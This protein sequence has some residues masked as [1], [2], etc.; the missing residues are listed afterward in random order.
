MIYAHSAIAG[1]AGY[2]IPV[3]KHSGIISGSVNDFIIY[4]FNIHP[5]FISFNYNFFSP[6]IFCTIHIISVFN[7][8]I[9]ST[10][11]FMKTVTYISALME[12]FFIVFCCRRAKNPGAGCP[13]PGLLLRKTSDL[14]FEGCIGFGVASTEGPAQDDSSRH[15]TVRVQGYSFIPTSPEIHYFLL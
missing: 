8:Y 2:W 6:I 14:Q 15:I 4:S 9:L 1:E 7:L 5:Q 11:Y 10:T 12:I 13:A 3:A